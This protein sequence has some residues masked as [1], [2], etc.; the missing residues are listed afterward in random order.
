METGP[1]LNR[2]ESWFF[3]A[4]QPVT[5]KVSTRS[6]LGKKLNIIFG[7]SSPFLSSNSYKSILH[8]F[9][10]LTLFSTSHPLEPSKGFPSPFL[11][12]SPTRYVPS[13]IA[14]SFQTVCSTT[15][16]SYPPSRTQ[17]SANHPRRPRSSLAIDDRRGRD[18][19][20]TLG[21]SAP[22]KK[23]PKRMIP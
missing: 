3:S 2:I 9:H 18:K 23:T 15:S 22:K 6:H 16:R 10:H 19:I 4:V 7:P 1:R 21:F 5:R 11:P 13:K 20:S 8:P 14:S 17:S 12:A